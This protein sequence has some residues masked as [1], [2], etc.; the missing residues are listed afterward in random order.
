MPL[1]IR[2][3]VE[4]VTL[5]GELRDTETAREIAAALPVEADVDAWGDEFYF[6]V[7][8]R[9]GLDETATSVVEVGDLGYWPPGPALALFF[10]PT[11]ASGPDGRPVPAS[12][13]SLVG[14]VRGAER[15]R[16]LRGARRIRVERA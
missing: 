12:E 15:L 3:L 9:R 2:I 4:G 7:P 16:A 6:E 14:R 1:A 10:G 8:V 5:E 13:V 11:P